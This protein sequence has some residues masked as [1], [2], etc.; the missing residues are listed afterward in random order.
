MSISWK[1]FFPIAAILSSIFLV[2]SSCNVEQKDGFSI[3]LIDNEE[4]VLSEYDIKAFYSADNTLELNENGIEKWN[5][6]LTYQTIPKL[7]DSL[8]SREFVIRIEGH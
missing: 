8:F 3:Y 6:Y 1:A 2:S 7:A 5:S 4:L